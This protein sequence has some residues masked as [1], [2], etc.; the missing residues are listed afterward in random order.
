RDA[1]AVADGLDWDELDVWGSHTGACV[2]LEMAIT[3]PDRIGRAV[4]EAPVMMAP[5]FREDIFAH[6]FPD[7]AP[8]AFG[9]H[10]P[11]VWNWRRDAVLYWPW[12][13]VD[14]AA[15]RAIG[16]P[17]ATDLHL[18]AVGILESGATYD[19]AYRAGFG[20]DTRSR[21]P[22]LRRPAMLTAGPH[23]MLANALDDA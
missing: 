15:G 6:Y 4:L 9:S 21:L 1:L 20:Y 11:R 19:G 22:H 13:R 7:L 8:D 16:L 17:S 5:E 2:A 23:D 3:A 18:Y 10:L 12:Y 14:H